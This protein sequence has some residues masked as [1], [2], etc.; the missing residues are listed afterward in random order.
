M[1]DLKNI[2]FRFPNAISAVGAR[3]EYTPER[4]LKKFMCLRDFSIVFQFLQ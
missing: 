4:K 3:L 2:S 1:V